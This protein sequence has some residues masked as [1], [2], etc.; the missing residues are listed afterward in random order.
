MAPEFLAA[1]YSP[2]LEFF[3]APTPS[4][5]IGLWGD[6]PHSRVVS[7]EQLAEEDPGLSNWI[8]IPA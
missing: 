8:G 2:L 5:T 1:S 6:N 3:H 7:I 4:K